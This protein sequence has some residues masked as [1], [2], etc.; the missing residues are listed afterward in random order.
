M[1]EPGT[2]GNIAKATVTTQSLGRRSITVGL[3]VLGALV[4]LQGL[5]PETPWTELHTLVKPMAAFGLGIQI[6]GGILR[7]GGE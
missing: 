7:S 6:L 4:G 1:P 5:A 3:I 2:V